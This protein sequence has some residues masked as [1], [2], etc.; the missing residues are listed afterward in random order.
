MEYMGLQNEKIF[1]QQPTTAAGFNTKFQES[2]KQHA[3]FSLAKEG[4]DNPH[5]SPLHPLG[6]LVANLG[7]RTFGYAQGTIETDGAWNKQTKIRCAA[8]MIQ[9]PENMQGKG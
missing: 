8:W 1:D 4:H 7:R 2:L 6:F 9:Q 5:T 3:T